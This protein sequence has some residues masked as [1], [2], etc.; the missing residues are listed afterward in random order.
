MIHYLKKSEINGT[1]KHLIRK[2][3][4]KLTAWEDAEP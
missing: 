2:Q 4:G 1:L 3:N